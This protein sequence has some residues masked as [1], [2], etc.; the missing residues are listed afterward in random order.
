MPAN[1]E[2]DNLSQILIVIIGLHST[3]IQSACLHGRTHIVQSPM[4]A[5]F[6]YNRIPHLRQKPFRGGCQNELVHLGSPKDPGVN[7]KRAFPVIA[8]SAYKR[9]ADYVYAWRAQALGM[10]RQG[11]ILD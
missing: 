8:L 7:F 1:S 3:G 2:G 10:A 6:A 9:Q 11:T 4:I 5:I